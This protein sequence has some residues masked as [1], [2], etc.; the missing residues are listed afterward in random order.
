MKTKFYSMMM[1]SVVGLCA[2]FVYAPVAQAQYS[3]PQNHSSHTWNTYQQDNTH[4][5]YH[6]P[7]YQN[8]YQDTFNYG[9]SYYNHA[10][11]PM[12]HPTPSQ[13]YYGGSSIY[14]FTHPQ[15]IYST[16]VFPTHWGGG[17]A[18]YVVGYHGQSHISDDDTPEVRTLSTQNITFNTARLRGEVDMNDFRNGRVFFV[19]GE[20][21]GDVEDAEDERRYGDIDQQGD[22]LQKLLVDNDLDDEESYSVTVFS[23]DENTRIYTRICVEYENNN[24]NDK[25]ECGRVEDFR[26]Q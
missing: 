19:Y 24:G 6:E 20:D 17:T 11:Y 18:N 23:L 7:N 3:Y 21:R 10:P 12:Y 26:T 8:Q 13:Y 2:V 15:E 5:W 25:I 4:S 9:H 14:Q 1:L 16:H 22:D